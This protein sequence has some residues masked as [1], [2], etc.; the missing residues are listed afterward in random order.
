MMRVAVVTGTR[1]DYGLLRPTLAALHTDARFD[2]QL[3]ACAMH[4]SGR[5]GMTVEAIEFPIAARIE[6]DPDDA[7][8]GALGRR[9]AAAVSGFTAAFEALEPD[10]LI[11]LG[12]R[13]EML[14]AALAA[15]AHAVPVLHIHGGELSEGSADD[16]MRHCITKLAHVHLVAARAYGERVCQLGEQPDRVHVT[17]AAALDSIRELELLDRDALGEA[18]DLR[19]GS[20]LV[21][22]TL[23]PASLQVETAGREA[24]EVLVGVD[25]SV[26][27]GATVIVSLPNDDPGN[28]AVRERLGAWVAS[29]RGAHAFES[30]GQRRYLSLLSHADVMVGNSSSGL[31]EAPAF[32]LPVVNVGDRQ[33]GRVAGAGVIP[34]AAE[35]G[36]VAG[37]VRRALDPAFRATLSPHA[38]P[39]GAGSVR[40]RVLEVLADL[41]DDVRDKRFLDLPDGPWRE[42]LRLR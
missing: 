6:T 32:A 29:R 13:Y 4:L 36:A 26:P 33:R 31:I 24:D 27:A 16:M 12:D 37:A 10:A 19:L 5:F 2:L 22:L 39:Y 1:A 8:P 15:M 17:G 38:N 11:V 3:V 7:A 23:H 42:E 21:A 18:L 35:R 40:D 28:F 20:P 34:C 9:L 25:A 41:P 30:L 14:G